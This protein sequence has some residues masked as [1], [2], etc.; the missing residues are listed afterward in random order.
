GPKAQLARQRHVLLPALE[1]FRPGIAGLTALSR[2]G[3]VSEGVPDRGGARPVPGCPFDLV[4]RGASPPPEVRAEVLHV[5]T[6][7][8]I[9]CM[10]LSS[11]SQSTMSARRP[12]SSA[13]MSPRPSTRAGPVAA[14]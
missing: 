11:L 4:G 10:A 7:F 13:P 9:T 12:A 5:L 14:R 3:Q 6:P 8:R 1:V 2:A